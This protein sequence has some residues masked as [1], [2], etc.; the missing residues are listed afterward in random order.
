MLAISSSCVQSKQAPHLCLGSMQLHLELC[1]PR[2]DWQQLFGI[3]IPARE[4]RE[5]CAA[6]YTQGWMRTQE[7]KEM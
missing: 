4:M 3:Q 7:V 6:L 1:N 2:L 5:H